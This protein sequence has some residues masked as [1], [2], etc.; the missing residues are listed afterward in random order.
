MEA[1][2]AEVSWNASFREPDNFHPQTPSTTPQVFR[3]EDQ[4]E[5]FR[6]ILPGVESGKICLS[7]ESQYCLSPGL[8]SNGIMCPVVLKLRIF[9]GFSSNNLCEDYEEKHSGN[10]NVV[11]AIGEFR[12]I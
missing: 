2:A 11:C 9:Y 8:R 5:L 12:S 4:I 7:P 10:L 6:L 3:F 1:L